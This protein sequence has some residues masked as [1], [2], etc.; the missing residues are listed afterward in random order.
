MQIIKSLKDEVNNLISKVAVLEEKQGNQSV[1]N[2]SVNQGQDRIEHEQLF[3]EFEDRRRRAKNVIITNVPESN[4]DT[5]EDKKSED[6]NAVMDLITH[7]G[8]EDVD[9]KKC[10]RIGKSIPN[11]NRPICVVF[12]TEDCKLSVLSK[13]RTRNNI[14]ISTDLTKMQQDKAYRVRKDFRA[15]VRDGEQGIRLKYHNGIPTIVHVK[16]Q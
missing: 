4:G 5:Q 13:Y 14:Y 8:L 12:P 9:I 3:E 10:Y 6:M 7:C 1:S 16:N 2:V 11:K 15:R